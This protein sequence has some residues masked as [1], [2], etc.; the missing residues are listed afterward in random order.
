MLMCH[1]KLM[2]TPADSNVV[3]VHGSN[4]NNFHQQRQRDKRQANEISP[5]YVQKIFIL[6]I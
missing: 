6:S 3:N 2:I 5:E 1:D 4:E